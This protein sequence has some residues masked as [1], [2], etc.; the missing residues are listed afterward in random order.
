MFWTLG[1]DTIY[2]HQDKEDDVLIGVKSSALALGRAQTRPWLFVFYAAA[3][4][5]WG[6]AGACGGAWPDSGSALAAAALQLA[7]RRHGSMTEDPLDCLAKFRSNRFG[8]LA[9]VC[10]DR[11]RPTP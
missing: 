8:R 10:R 2:A 6:A 3:L 11:L 5:L 4:L 9:A 7:G 1:Y